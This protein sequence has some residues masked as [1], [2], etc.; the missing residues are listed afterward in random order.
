M[1]PS[2][3]AWYIIS[4]ADK[5]I[6]KVE[7]D[8]ETG[9]VI[10]KL[11][12]VAKKSKETASEMK[13]QLSGALGQI[14]K[15]TG[16]AITKV[17]GLIKG[18]KGV[19][20]GMKSLKAAIASTGIGLLVIA[21]G[22]LVAYFTS[23]KRGS[24]KLERV[25]TTLSAA[26][27]VITDRLSAF[28]E[29]LVNAFENPQQAIKDFGESLKTF[30]MNRVR[31]LINGVKGLGTAI[32]LLFDGEFLEAGKA[33]GQAFLDIGSAVVPLAGLIRDNADAI[34]EMVDEINREA[35]AANKLTGQLQRLTDLERNLGVERAAAGVQIAA[36]KLASE[37]LTK[38]T[39]E[40]LEAAQ[41]AFD[42]EQQILEKEL[43]A[44]RQRVS[45]I[46]QQ[47]ALGESSADD[48]DRLAEARKA[49]YALEE[50]SL[51]RQTELQNKK[52][53][54]EAEG[55]RKALEAVKVFRDAQEEYEA[56]QKARK[57]AD[58]D[59][60]DKL[61]ETL[62]NRSMTEI[63]A[64]E[65]KYAKLA[66]LAHGHAKLIEQIEEKKA[67]DIE[68]IEDEKFK[69]KVARFDA[70]V[71]KNVSVANNLL[72]NLIALNDASDK[73]TDG[74]KR[75]AFER[76]KK[77]RIAQATI[78]MIQGAS[79]AFQQGVSTYPVP[80]GAII[81]GVMAAVSVAAGIAQIAK[82]KK[83]TY[84]GGG[85]GGGGGAPSARTASLPSGNNAP[86]APSIQ[87]DIGQGETQGSIRAY[88]VSKDT[89]NQ[90][91]KDQLVQD[92]AQLV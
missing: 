56:K 80:F 58:K 89:T 37:D 81:G 27:S 33:A 38:T 84:N 44:A 15:L 30:V 78:T 17:Q 41:A 48:L 87:G 53:A 74:A 59:D 22:S 10:T 20:I 63:E 9:D 18:V 92:Q 14:D 31:D 39:E 36:N 67:N 3:V 54:I 75:K 62:A 7:I 34:G 69:K 64:V 13:N 1:L 57:D 71:Q 50:G 46:A 83:T 60:Q 5:R 2:G 19:T 47:N 65:A 21:L 51:G 70:E 72:G 42:L 76:D 91:S 86:K 11:E 6:I 55:A 40:R 73:A 32:G 12:G 82:I 85:G 28:G 45:I 35:A 16:G 24:E 29:T 25:M 52:N 23:T 77:L 66:E 68:I 4:M 43:S 90:Q 26:F 79:G 88:V 49:L 61:R 8:A